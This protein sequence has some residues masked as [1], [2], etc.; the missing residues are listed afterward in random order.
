MGCHLLSDEIR[1]KALA[2]PYVFL[3]LYQEKSKNKTDYTL[4]LEQQSRVMQQ[5]EG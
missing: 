4:L 1:L 5:H 3:I 2:I